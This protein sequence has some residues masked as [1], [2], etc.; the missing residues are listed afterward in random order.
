MMPDMTSKVGPGRRPRVFD[1]AGHGHLG[2][3]QSA[4]AAE[5]VAGRVEA[6]PAV[7]RPARAPC[8]LAAA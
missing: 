2:R 8:A 3:T 7:A 1:N 5:T 6:C 4:A